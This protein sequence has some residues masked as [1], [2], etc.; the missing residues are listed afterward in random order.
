MY[1][2]IG[3]PARRSPVGGQYVSPGTFRRQLR[4]L[5]AMGAPVIT[6]DA[7]GEHVRG[8]AQLSSRHVAITFDDGFE[9]LYQH[10]FPALRAIGFPATIFLISR[11]LGKRNTYHA[12]EHDL[13]EPLLNLDQIRDMLTHGIV[14]GSH[15]RRH[16]RLTECTESELTDEIAGS[17]QDLEELIGGPVPWFCY[18]YGAQTPAIRD[19]VEQAGY[20]LACSTLKGRN[21]RGSDPLLLRRINVRA[22]TRLPVFLYKLARARFLAR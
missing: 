17:R 6:L 5:K 22:D 2:R 16:A 12:P 9:N 20:T 4:L 19:R 15:T 21:D 13:Y 18:P 7:V 1:H 10:A 8:E 14:F 3:R 11:Y